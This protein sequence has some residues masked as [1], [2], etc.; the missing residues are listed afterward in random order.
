MAKFTSDPLVLPGNIRT[1]DSTANFNLGA[2]AVTSGGRIFRYVKCG[3]TAL[4]AGKLYDGPAIIT[5][6]VNIAVQAAAA[7][8]ATSVTVTLGGTEVT[9]NQYDQDGLLIINDVDGEGFSYTIKS[10]PTA[11]ASANIVITLDDDETIV[12]ALTTSSQASLISNQYN[13]II[14]HPSTETG[15]PVGVANT[16]ITAS[17]FGWIQTRGSV[18][19]LHD[20]T[21]AALGD[22]V[23]ASNATIGAVTKDVAILCPIGYMLADGVSTE[24]NPIFLTID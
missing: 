14:V 19:C 2:K 13:G 11:D 17:Q 1:D 15:I 9:A 8:L 10:H 7:A 4:V 20:S 24:F 21:N 22:G 16:Q 23:S 5:D 18:S 12:T 3:G 6:H